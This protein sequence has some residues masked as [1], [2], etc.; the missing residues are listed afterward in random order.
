MSSLNKNALSETDIISK[1]IMLAIK[2]N[3][4]DLSLLSHLSLRQMFH[5]E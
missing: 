3:V 1:Y 4:R 5:S 2:Q